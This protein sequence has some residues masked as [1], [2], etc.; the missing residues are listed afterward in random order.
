MT[1]QQNKQML[2]AQEQIS[3]GHRILCQA[4]CMTIITHEGVAQ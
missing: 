3:P 4:Q 1:S 2:A